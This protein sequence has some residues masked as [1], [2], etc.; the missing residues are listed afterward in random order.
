MNT[1]E[2]DYS[3]WFFGITVLMIFSGVGRSLSKLVSA[4][5]LGHSGLALAM[6][7]CEIV[8]AAL[9]I[10]ILNKKKWGLYAFL[11]MMLMQI[12]L[13]Y[14]LGVGNMGQVYLSVFVRITIIFL[15]LLIPSEGIPAWKI[16][17]GDDFFK[18]RKT[19]TSSFPSKDK[20]RAADIQPEPH[21]ISCDNKDQLDIANSVETNQSENIE[22]END[23]QYTFPPTNIPHYNGHERSSLFIALIAV[24]VLCIILVIFVVADHWHSS[25]PSDIKYFYVEN[26]KLHLDPKCSDGLVYYSANDHFK[27]KANG[28]LHGQYCSKCIK[29]KQLDQI[30]DSISFYRFMK[31]EYNY[32]K[33]M[34]RVWTWLNYH[35]QMD[36]ILN[37]SESMK[38]P[39]NRSSVFKAIQDSGTLN[40]G[41]N[42]SEFYQYLYGGYSVFDLNGITKYIPNDEVEAFVRVYPSAT[43]IAIRE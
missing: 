29:E 2:P 8:N 15:M 11:V 6:V 24:S 26:G 34:K 40:V 31:D 5:A 12:P 9:L 1:K 33:N 39:I 18:R 42:T 7:L 36:G 20:N 21:A 32:T 35:Y 4:L 43:Q 10:A 23:P 19:R 38:D 30:M 28:N 3:F 41:T 13:N 17:L 22:K 37:T 16:L 27:K 14:F 25:R